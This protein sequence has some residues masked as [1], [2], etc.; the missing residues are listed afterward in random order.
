M[1][2]RLARHRIKQRQLAANSGAI[3]MAFMAQMRRQQNTRAS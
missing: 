3:T 1:G 2:V